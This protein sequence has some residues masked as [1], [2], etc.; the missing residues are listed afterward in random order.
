MRCGKLFR[1]APVNLAAGA[2][3]SRA[4][5]LI[6]GAFGDGTALAPA[7]F[8]HADEKMALTTAIR[9]VATSVARR[10]TRPGARRTARELPSRR[11][12]AIALLLDDHARIRQL[13]VRF[14]GLL[15]SGRQKAA[16]VTRI[17]D[18]VE[19]HARIEEEIF[20]PS[21]RALIAAD[22]LMDEAAVEHEVARALIAQLRPLRPGD[23]HYDAK[24]VVLDA[25]TRHHFD[26]EEQRIFP[27]AR[28]LR[29]DL[30][31]LGRAL[32]ARRRQ[33][34]C[35]VTALATGPKPIGSG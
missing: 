25:Y 28:D 35:A 6:S 32:K 33:L 24:V 20:Y 11:E 31:A 13:F 1:R 10:V 16:L 9:G 30:V 8:D 7:F 4:K 34:K 3:E 29:I 18:E 5:S 22:E 19:L 14:E 26:R 2:C 21:V 15:S 27:R 17:C 23:F 12:D